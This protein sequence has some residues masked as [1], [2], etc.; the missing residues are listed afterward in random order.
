MLHILM[1]SS[2]DNAPTWAVNMSLKSW[3]FFFF[4]FH[5][6]L[7]KTFT[8]EIESRFCEYKIPSSARD[9]FREVKRKDAVD[10]F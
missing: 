10:S 5:P 7:A 8:K 2:N 3:S 4:I 1:F 9:E 6:N